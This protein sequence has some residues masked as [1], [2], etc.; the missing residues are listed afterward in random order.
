MEVSHPLDAYVPPYVRWRLAADPASPLGPFEDVYQAAVIHADISG[1]TALAEELAALGGAGAEHV[2]DTLRLFFQE[3]GE[4]VAF[5]GGHTLSFAGDSATAFWPVTEPRMLPTAA[6]MAVR[7][8]VAINRRLSGRPLRGG[9]SQLDIHASVG[10]GEVRTASVGGVEGRW[11]PMVF[12]EAVH[13]V[14]ET[15]HQAQSG[16]V[17]VS[18]DAWPL[19]RAHVLGQPVADGTVRV[20]RAPITA[21]EPSL[22]IL[23]QVTA[24]D[25]V[26]RAYVPG[27]VQARLAERAV[28]WLA[29]FR[30]ATVAFIFLRNR[31][32]LP[33][34]LDSVQGMVRPV[35]EIVR[36]TGGSV[37]KVLADRNGIAVVAA[38]G[39]PQ[40]A[41][42]DNAVRAVRAATAVEACIRGLGSVATIGIASGRLYMGQAGTDDHKEYALIGD[43]VNV[44]ARL[45]DETPAGIRCDATTRLDAR[46]RHAFEALPAL[47]VR[48]RTQ[49]VPIY[50]PW[51]RAPWRTRPAHR[52]RG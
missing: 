50:R 20:R 39:L 44:A 40:H 25:A 33:A 9:L 21:P 5:N 1:F 13:Q 17:V 28:E 37:N 4:I 27:S 19:I 11:L 48:G 3:L 51:R 22:A 43:V 26:I 10:A 38:W 6:L 18:R 35:H 47:S 41:H 29:E 14:L 24:T 30:H 31:E 49:P 42:E 23:Q 8:A 7:C 15:Q 36:S 12:G 34:G 45:V 2:C 46:S 32:G 16:E 52:S